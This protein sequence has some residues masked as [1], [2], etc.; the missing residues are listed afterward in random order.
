MKLDAELVRALVREQF[1]EWGGLPVR[2]VPRQGWDNRTFRL[3]DRLVVRLPSAEGYV[4][5]VEKEDRC[6]PRLAGHL[7]LPVPVP[8][9]T[10]RPGLGYP[11]PW[12]VRRWLPGE[13]VE[14]AADVDRIR[15]ARDLGAFLA[16]LREAPER[17]P[18]GGPHSYYRG[19]HPSV[20][21]HEVESA[22]DALG[23]AVDVAACRAVWADALG[24]AWP[25]APVW[26]HGDVAVGNLLTT[27]GVLSA[28][29]DFGTC[30]VGDPACDLVMAWTFFDGAE[31]KV[32]RE[33][34]GLPDDA[35]RR[36][37]GWALWK[38]LATMARLSSPDP[39]G[40]QSRVLERIIAD[41]VVG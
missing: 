2:P 1:P 39:E 5:A 14:T 18:F 7:P 28:V 16:A 32:F 23:N 3:G 19:C 10:G 20:Y 4:P 27:G 31:R 13:T 36:A 25:E 6:L 26:F 41:P 38:A 17:G 34:V 33:A 21:G 40:F 29:I 35:W 15:L 12:S 9:A 24:S 30:G 8:V 37:R 22:L 11:F